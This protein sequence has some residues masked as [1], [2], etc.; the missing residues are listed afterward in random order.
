MSVKHLCEICAQ[1][2]GV[3]K[4]DGC[5]KILCKQCRQIEIWGSGAEDLTVKYFCNKCKEDSE[6]NP[7]GACNMVFGLEEVTDLVN[8][9]IKVEP[10]SGFKIKVHVSYNK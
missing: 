6:I 9:D 4:C 1:R 10:E 5:G 3:A 8:K 7:W 2:V